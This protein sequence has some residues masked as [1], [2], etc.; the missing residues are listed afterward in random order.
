M[1]Y[2]NAHEEPV[3]RYPNHLKIGFVGLGKLGLPVAACWAQAHDVLGYDVLPHRMTHGPVS[4]IEAGWGRFKDLNE[5]LAGSSRLRFGQLDEIV[6]TCELVFLC[7]QTP[8][9]PKFEGTVPVD[10]EERRDF[11]YQHL[12][13]ATR[14]LLRELPENKELLLAVISTVLPGTMEREIKPLLPSNVRLLYNPAFPAMGTAVPDFMDPEFWLIGVDDDEP[15]RNGLRPSAVLSNAY[16]EMWSGNA[17]RPTAPPSLVMSIPSAELAKVAYN[18]AISTKLMVANALMDLCDKLPGADCDSVTSVLRNAWRRVSSSQYWRGGNGDGGNCH[19]RDNIAMSWLARLLKLHCN[20]FE[21]AMRARD[22]HANWFAQMLVEATQ[23]QRLPMAIV[24]YAYK[25]Q[26]ALT[27]GSHALL[28][29][30]FLKRK[31]HAVEMI[32]PVV[33]PDRIA[34]FRA[35]MRRD[36][37]AV[38]IGCA[39]QELRDWLWAPDSIII[40]P[41]RMIKDQDRVTVI[42]V[43][44]GARG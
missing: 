40:D 4:E 8:H 32:D 9:D 24:G 16:L 22:A 29:Q 42:R 21:E 10:F 23:K 7:V 41:H 36:P 37:H 44:E 18:C 14:N 28:V 30:A 35:R 17:L 13:S 31:G 20:P 39:H 15:M 43:G 25:P 38:L 2:E 27:G 11:G 26:C 1:R 34:E 33:E 19:P 6:R 5:M 12:V 3:S